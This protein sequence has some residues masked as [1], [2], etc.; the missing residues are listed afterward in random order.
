MTE[1]FPVLVTGATG[2]LG[3]KTCEALLRK[4]FDVRATD[5]KLPPDFEFATELGDLKD[6]YFVHRLMRDVR[7]V[8]HLGNHPNQFAGPSPQRILAENTQM[9]ANVF[10]ACVQHGIERLVFASSVQA[11]LYTDFD[12]R[13]SR[14]RLPY[15]PLDS[16]APCAPGPNTYGQ[17]KEFAE[18]MLQHLVAAHPRL[19]ATSL[20]FPMLVNDHLLSRFESVRTLSQNWFNFSE[21]ISHLT[22]EDAGELIALLVE[23]STPGYRQYFPALAMQFKGRTPADLIRQF[24][25]DTPLKQPIDEIAELID[26]SD[27]TR[28]VGWKPT[29]RILVPIDD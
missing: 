20:R 26:I 24:Y 22:F 11:F 18:R 4:G 15:L 10:H 16:H 6:E 13:P 3:A 1:K 27:I 23:Q 7:A 14:F 5:Q 9:N 12:A 2:K 17:S 29:R 19:S 28:D 21:C 25:P 8:V